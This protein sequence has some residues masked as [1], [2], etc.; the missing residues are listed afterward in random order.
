MN[1]IPLGDKILVSVI[2][3]QEEKI[4]SV[5]VPGTANAE[6]RLGK[7]EAVSPQLK[8]VYNVGDVV[9]F[10]KGC[11]VGQYVDGKPHLWLRAMPMTTDT[12]VWGIEEK[13]N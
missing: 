6:L 5:I 2:D 9:L 4:G 11:G 7:V 3:K 12:E 10:P 8:D 1:K 13:A